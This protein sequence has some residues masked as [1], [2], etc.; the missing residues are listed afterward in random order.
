MWFNTITSIESLFKP[1]YNID[2]KVDKEEKKMQM[3]VVLAFGIIVV[4]QAFGDIISERTGGRLPSIFVSALLFLIGFW[5][6]LPTEIVQNVGGEEIK[7]TL[8]EISGISAPLFGIFLT[9][10]VTHMG[11][12][13][14]IKEL[15]QQWK[16]IIIGV[17]G[18]VGVMVFAYFV[19]GAIFGKE[20][21]LVA[22]PPL[23]GG[24]AA[25][26]IM[27]SAANEVGREDLALVSTLV[28]SLQG[29]LGY[30]IMNF[31]LRK[32]SKAILDKYGKGEISLKDTNNESTKSKN[33]F[34]IIPP[35]PKKYQ[36][37]TVLIAKVAFVSWLAES[38]A[39]VTGGVIHTYV[40]CLILGIVAAEIG[41]LEKEI[42]SKSETMGLMMV[43][44]MGFVFGGLASAT[45]DKLLEVAAPLLG[46]MVIGVL[47]LI[48]LGIIVGKFF[49]ETWMMSTAI[50]INC[51]SGFPP[52]YIITKG[53][54]ESMSSNEEEYN[55][56]MQEMLPKV[57]V[58][59]FVTVTVAS[60]LVANLFA[61]QL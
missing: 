20:Y 44:I 43:M 57:L 48:I 18:I 34:K 2:K 59:G 40:M 49:G 54:A 19:S 17:A 46:T 23:A 22:A 39:N 3:T 21:G 12:L 41:F 30:P 16:T 8:L 11:S 37:S 35:L 47:G 45:P 1:T 51:L 56:L 61:A 26:D 52:N 28:F 9:L 42:L 38:L 58:G 10:L 32:E 13:M 33:R 4:L 50:V 60:V 53:A 6:I 25:M 24:L 14:S 31:A 29:L 36:T 15:A 5:T 27:V 7:K 55:V